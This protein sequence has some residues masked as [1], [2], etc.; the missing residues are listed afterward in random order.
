MSIGVRES[1]CPNCG[2]KLVGSA[3]LEC[4]SC[5][6]PIRKGLKECPVCNADLSGTS[7]RSKPKSGKKTTGARSQS[8]KKKTADPQKTDLVI[9]EQIQVRDEDKKFSC[10]KCAGLLVGTESKCPKCGQLLRGKSGPRCRICGTPVKKGLKECP[11]CTVAPEKISDR[12]KP[13]I[14]LESK[15]VEKSP[16]EVSVVAKPE[17]PLDSKPE[18]KLPDE[19]PY[20]TLPATRPCSFCGAII[21]ENLEKCPLC[22]AS[23]VETKP[24]EEAS[25]PDAELSKAQ[26]SEVSAPAPAEAVARATSPTKVRKLRTVKV[27]TVPVPAQ[28]STRG[29]TNGVGY[30]NGLSKVDR[31]DAIKGEAFVNGTGISNGLGARPKELSARRTSFLTRWQLLAVLVAIVVIIPTF[32]FL[33]YSNESEEFSIDGEFSDWAGATTYGTRIQS[34][35]ST[36]NVTEWS[37]ATQSSDLFLYIKTQAHMMS[38]PNAE[39]YYLFVDSDGS[40]TTGYVMESIGADYMLQLTGWDSAVRST[41]ISRYSSSS[42]H[43]NWSAWTSTGSLSCSLDLSRLE[44]GV[45]M[46]VA[47]GQSAKFVLV[48]KDSA[49]CGSVSYT[50]PLKG[51]ALIVEQVPS[52]EVTADGIL[53]KS[54]SVAILTLRFTCQGEG[55]RVDSVNP[56]MTGATLAHQEPAFSLSKGEVHETVIAVNTSTALDGQFVS[57]EVLASGIGSSF[58]SIEIVGS[59]ASAYV[60]SRPAVI[61]IDG[62]FADWTGRL[63]LDQDSTPITSSDTDIDA[64]GNMSTSQDAYFYVSVEGEMCSGTFVPAMVAKPSGPGGGGAVIQTRH[65]A[66]DILRIYVDND[67]SN[68]TGK[69]V[70]FNSKQIGAEQLIEVKGLFGKITS[71]KEFNCSSSGTWVEMVDVVDAAKDAKRIEISVSAASIGGSADIDYIVETTS[72]KGRSDLATFDPSTM[73]A[74]TR[75]WIVDP[76]STSPYATSMSYQRKMFYDGVN[77]WSFFFDGANTVHKFSVDD[78]QTWKDSGTVFTTLGVNETSMWYDS[79]TSTVYAVGDTSMVTNNVSIQVGTVD[80][81]AHSILWAA[82]DSGLNTSMFPLAGKNTYISKDSNGYLWLLSSNCTRSTPPIRHQLTAFRSAAVNSTLSWVNSGQMLVT[83]SAS[84]NVKGSIVPSGSGSD[85]WAVYAYGGNVAARKYDG[86]WQAAVVIYTV[87]ASTANTDNSPPSVVVDKKGV[88]HVVYGTGRRSGVLSAPMIQYSHNDTG[89][90]TFTLGVDLDPLIV[91]NVGDYYPTISLE[92]STG[93]LYAFWLQSDTS[94]SPKTVMGSKCVSDAWSYIT[95]QA[96]TSFTKRYLI[97]IYSVSG[98]FKISWQW[99]QNA[100]KPIDVLIDHQEVPEF[101]D[102]T[103]PIIGVIAIFAVTRK[104]S[105]SKEDRFD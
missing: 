63:S 92:S 101:S 67:K 10:P 26:P 27:A 53:P 31:T 90:T 57:A 14:P 62:A 47:L 85:V 84:D 88:V 79:A 73:S 28:A 4:P 17:I 60:G 89:L 98:E 1:A 44:A 66:E 5:G 19:V 80:A 37:I 64:V 78:G 54:T 87:G 30:V 29:L 74:S 2:V 11:S 96:Q 35:S 21:P 6:E 105:R 45:T 83:A 16:D 103:L 72:W 59:S 51:G 104:R 8:A 50:A 58:A 24:Q 18:D 49:D 41:S 76:S 13:E 40:S 102:L 95:I 42:D 71:M 15:T 55:G 7:G 100:T 97:S 34:T 69:V 23:F 36:S 33:S 52:V 3:K 77:Y 22:N 65:T 99:T 46:P 9:D 56:I 68:S 32:I 39:S 75:T 93:D 43:Y 82:I 38:S 12:A 25:G 20:V 70:A 48:S 91:N 86:T 94:L 81:S 61:A